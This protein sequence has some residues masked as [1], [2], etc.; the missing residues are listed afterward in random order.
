MKPATTE[1]KELR[2]NEVKSSS[3]KNK[4]KKPDS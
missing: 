1:E 4:D 3:N 2:P